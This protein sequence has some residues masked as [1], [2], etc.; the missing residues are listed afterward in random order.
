MTNEELRE[1]GASNDQ[2]QMYN[3]LKV[4]MGI[5]AEKEFWRIILIEAQAR[6]MEQDKDGYYV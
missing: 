3:D 1:L 2:I 6:Q 5:D 4:I